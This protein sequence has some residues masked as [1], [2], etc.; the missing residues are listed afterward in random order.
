MGLAGKCTGYDSFFGAFKA[1]MNG[2]CEYLIGRIAVGISIL[3]KLGAKDIKP[4]MSIDSSSMF[5][6]LSPDTKEILANAFE[7][8]RQNHLTQA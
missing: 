6:W 2:E 8:D 1:L 5:F 4:L 7:E 3:E